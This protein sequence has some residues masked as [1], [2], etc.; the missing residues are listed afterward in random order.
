MVTEYR[1]E[2]QRAGPRVVAVYMETVRYD[3]YLE[4]QGEWQHMKKKGRQIRG[5]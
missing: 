3:R 4:K 5:F 2:M 1:K